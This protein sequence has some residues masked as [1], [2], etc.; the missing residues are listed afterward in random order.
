MNS[1]RAL[2]NRLTHEFPNDRELAGEIAAA[3][4]IDEILAVLAVSYR[5]ALSEAA[6]AAAADPTD[7]FRVEGVE[8]AAA[9]REDVL[10]QLLAFFERN[11]A[12]TPD[13]EVRRTGPQA[14]RVVCRQPLTPVAR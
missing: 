4:S 12:A 13:V 3:T 9:A 1:F 8:R 10:L 11:R 5:A 6:A 2:K 14:L 7:R